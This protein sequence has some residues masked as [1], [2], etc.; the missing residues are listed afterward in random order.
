M[1]KYFYRTPRIPR[2]L[3]NEYREGILVGSACD[4]GEVFTAVMQKDQEEVE[5]IARYYDYLEVQPKALYQHLLDKDLIRDNETMEEIY[6]RIL[7]VGEKLDIPVLATGNVHYLNEHDKIAR[8]ILIASNPGNPLNRQTL[9]DA[10]FRTTDEMLDAF[11]FLGE[12]K[13]YEIVIKNTNE[14]ADRIETVIPIQ[15]KLFTPNIDGANE[16]IREMSYARARSIY[17][18][19]LP[20]IVV[21]RLEKELDSIIG[22]GFAV[23]YLISQKLVKKVWMMVTW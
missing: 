13:A 18:E 15:D 4:N 2:S 20:E 12:E 10:H 6:Q 14:L 5:K 21:A 1:V 23:I 19:E 22:N 7:D 9:P 3:L 17:G 11:H 16:E 8:E